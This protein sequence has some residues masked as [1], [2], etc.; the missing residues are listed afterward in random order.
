LCTGDADGALTRASDAAGVYTLL[1]PD[2]QSPDLRKQW[3]Q[4]GEAIVKAIRNSGVRYVVFLSSIG[5]DLPEGTGPIA[6]LHAQEEPTEAARRQLAHLASSVVGENFCAI[7]GLIKNQDQRRCRTPDLGYRGHDTRIARC[8]ARA[9]HWTGIVVRER[10]GARD[11]VRRSDAH[12]RHARIGKPDLRYVQ[13]P[14]ADFASSLVQMGISQNMAG[15]YAKM[16]RAFNEG[17]IKSREGR[18]PE[19]TTP[20]RLED[21]AEVLVRAYEAA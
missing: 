18:R 19:N 6:G 9:R 1:P 15:L 21:F 4:E 13:F 20:T 12:H 17:K 3:D 16:A 2:P 5:A 11:L 14:Y 7:L 10:L 8:R